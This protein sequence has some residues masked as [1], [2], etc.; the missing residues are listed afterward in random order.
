[1][2]ELAA[3]AP[4]IAI[5]SMFAIHHPECASDAKG[6]ERI[7]FFTGNQRAHDS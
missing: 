3:R 2:V 1:M 4:V 7:C 6:Y 5:I